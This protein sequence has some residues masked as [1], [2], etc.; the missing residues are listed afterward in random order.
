MSE[1]PRAE[2]LDE[3]IARSSRLVD[4]RLA[5]TLPRRPGEV[6]FDALDYHLSTGGKR[7][8]P[9]LCLLTCEALGGRTEDALDFAVAVELLHNM[10]LVHDDVEDGDEVRRD[11]PALWVKYGLAH[12]VNAGDYLLG[13]AYQAVL[14]APGDPARRCRLLD[15]FNA[16]VLRTIEGQAL[17]IASRADP[18]W[19]VEA[20]RHMVEL[21]TGWYLSLGMVGAAILA[22]AG[23]AAVAHLEAFGR[24]AGPAF[25]VR[26]D[27]LDLTPGKGRGGQIGSDVREGKASILYAHAL[28]AAA[29][30]E[31]ERLVAIMA[32]PRPETTDADVAWVLDLYRRTGALEFARRFSED[33]LRE[34]K[35]HIAALPLRPGE[36]LT[37]LAD[38]LIGRVR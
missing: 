27:V 34:A 1:T 31:R 14:R 13:A 18:N 37:A 28:Q 2:T 24:C 16:T 5:E 21:K 6:L 17:D 9:A 19:T 20:Y 8:R 36:R 25:Q 29:P 26:D 15:A 23:D 11:R 4:Q 22:G 35:A 33:L 10:F 38:H 3:A 32:R 7:L 30:D 12:A